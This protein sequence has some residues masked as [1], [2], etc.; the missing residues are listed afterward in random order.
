MCF[1]YFLN[2]AINILVLLNMETQKLE[3]GTNYELV[4]ANRYIEDALNILVLI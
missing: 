4:H 3:T 1:V 2:F